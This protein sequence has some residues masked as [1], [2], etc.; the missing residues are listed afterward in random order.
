M[1]GKVIQLEQLCS[2]RHLGL[3]FTRAARLPGDT[4][5]SQ[6]W[7]LS[8]RDRVCMVIAA[9]SHFGAWCRSLGYEFGEVRADHVD[10]IRNMETLSKVLCVSFKMVS[11]LITYIK[12]I[13]VTRHPQYQVPT[14]DPMRES[15]SVSPGICCRISTGLCVFLPSPY[16]PASPH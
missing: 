13:M 4:V 12:N 5:T 10:R 7:C 6:Q 1:F 8:P 14:T 11:V 2:V 15:L 16:S 3:D 9:D